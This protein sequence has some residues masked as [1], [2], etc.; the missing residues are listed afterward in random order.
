[1]VKKTRKVYAPLAGCLQLNY[2]GYFYVPERVQ[3]NCAAIIR[4]GQVH[5][6]VAST[7]GPVKDAP[8]VIATRI[9]GSMTG[10]EYNTW[11]RTERQTK[12]FR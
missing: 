12:A 9:D 1:M 7:P 5:E 11:R 2:M 6:I 4:V 3:D 8:E 10:R